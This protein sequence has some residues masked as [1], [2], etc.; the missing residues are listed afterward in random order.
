[1]KFGT[2]SLTYV[3]AA[4]YSKVG[5]AGIARYVPMIVAIDIYV[6]DS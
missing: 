6:S 5:W 2:M 1:M 4:F 3:K